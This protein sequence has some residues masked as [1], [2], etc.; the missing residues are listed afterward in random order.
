MDGIIYK[1][2]N[3]INGKVYIGQTINE[4]VRKSSHKHCNGKCYFHNAIQKYGYD[5][6]NYEIIERLDEQLLD[7]R[8]IYWI[9]F[10][11]SNNSSFGY[12]LT[13]G[14]E[15]SRGRKLSEE[16]KQKL[17][18]SK[19][20]KPTPEETRQRISEALKGRKHSEE[21]KRKMSES[22]KGKPSKLKGR[23]LSEE[24]K[25]K[26]SD[27]L[28]GRPLPEETKRKMSESHKKYII[29]NTN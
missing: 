15:G 29:K 27:T 21:S 18:N 24:T 3:R 2:T 7:E 23:P 1:Y 5:N 16:H 14:G 6:F 28:R 10:Y 25:R 26:I 19:K 8:E 11:K 13:S 4:S 17:I 22:K 12:N 20:N 9:S